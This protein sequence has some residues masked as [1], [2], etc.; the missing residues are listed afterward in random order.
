MYRRP[1]SP[2]GPMATVAAIVAAQ[3]YDSEEH[4][5]FER[6]RWYP[7]K[8]APNLPFVATV[9]M[10]VLALL[11]GL[12][13]LFSAM[14]NHRVDAVRDYDAEVQHWQDVD[15][16]QLEQAQVQLVATLPPQ[17]PGGE[18]VTLRGSLEPM[19]EDDWS[20]ADAEDGLGVEDYKPLSFRIRLE[21]PCY[22]NNCSMVE[23][24][25]RGHL[26]PR[27]EWEDEILPSWDE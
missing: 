5:H 25:W 21:L 2:Q 4:P 6:R 7:T 8:R 18:P 17:R 23:A 12:S 19:E 14:V 1:T 16:P 10:G 26:S 27:D 22:Y 9:C 24:N 13:F 15:R 20:F 11:V 3:N